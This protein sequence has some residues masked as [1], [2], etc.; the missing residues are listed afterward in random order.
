MPRAQEYREM[1]LILLRRSFLFAILKYNAA[2]KMQTF[3]HILHAYLNQSLQS[4]PAAKYVIAG[5][6]FPNVCDILLFARRKT[7][8]AG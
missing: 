7:N 4:S 3:P 2:V 8:I 1:F 6:T 5:L